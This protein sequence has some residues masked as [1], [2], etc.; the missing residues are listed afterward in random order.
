MAKEPLATPLDR[1]YGGFNALPRGI[2][3]GTDPSLIADGQLAFASNLSFRGDLVHT[4]SPLVS[5]PLD[6]QL[7]GMF[8]G[9]GFYEMPTQQGIVLTVA[10]RFYLIQVTPSDLGAVTDITPPAFSYPATIDFVHIFQAEKYAIFLGLQQKPVIYDGLTSRTAGIKE[11]PSGVLGLYA[12][13]RIWVALS[14]F[15]TFA[16]GDIVYG[17]S[18]TPAEG[19]VDAILKFTE[20][21]FLNEGGFFAVPSSAGTITAMIALATIDTS[22]GIGPILIGTNT[23]VISVNA[24]VDRTTWKNLQY[25]I[26]TISLL[27]YGPVGPRSTVSAFNDV[28]FRSLDGVRSFIVARRN[29]VSPG[30]VPLSHEVSPVLANDDDPLLFKGSAIVFD[31]RLFMTVAPRLVADSGTVHDGLAV[32]NFDSLSTMAGKQ[33]PIWE[34]VRS[35]LAILQVVRGHIRGVERAFALALN[36][37]NGVIELWEITRE[38]SGYY[39]TYRAVAGD[40]TSIVRTSI[41]TA[42]ETKR[43]DYDRLVK[44]VMG[45]L[46]LDDIVDEITL[47]IK[48]KPDEYPGWITWATIHLC[49]SVSQCTIATPE[50]FTCHIWKPNAR[51]YAARI[52]LPRPPETC[53]EIAGTPIDRAY[54][55]QFRLEGTGHFQTRKFRPHLKVESDA[56]E[57]TCPTSAVCTA[58]ENC[59]LPWFDYTIDRG[60]MAPV[61]DLSVASTP[62]N[63]IVEWE[64]ASA[65]DENEVWRSK[66]GG[67]FALLATVAG[68]VTSYADT[69]AMAAMDIWCYKVRG[70]GTDF[71]NVGCAVQDLIF[72]DTGAVSQPTWMLAYGDFGADNPPAVTSLSLPA[73]KRV[74]GNLFLDGMTALTSLSL[75]ALQ[76]V[77][78]T[79]LL[80]LSTMPALTFPALTTVGAAIDASICSNLVTLDAPVLAS[81][82]GNV[83]F[84]SNALVTVS[85]P[86]LVMLNGKTYAF[87]NNAMTAASVEGL[88]ARGAAQLPGLTTASILLDAGTN[89]G[90]A[91]LS[92]QGQ[93]DR[94]DLVAAGDTVPVN[95]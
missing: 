61:L 76:S 57:G 84:D 25:P 60:V 36:E 28:W 66:N 93:S 80:S 48:F 75:P 77:G 46:Y 51:T 38:N 4:R 87:D 6:M 16:A 13:G 73:L 24:P 64:Q 74:Y 5:I 68:T 52:R 15:R 35:G 54:S 21:D 2:D 12:W 42:L 32:I 11:I 50:Q 33:P 71:S 37:S 1:L 90:L 8:G 26:Q 81:V 67:A 45:E 27:D 9:A 70:T 55:F 88:L 83:E 43:F 7:T 19:G 62:G 17:P 89:A 40:H 44:L 23:S 86:V 31:N 49:A 20:N 47:V 59:E 82:G 22:L 39:D 78:V 41:Q 94:A 29:T 10:G 95:P 3:Y 79:F 56:F 53:N 91:S 58:V 34:G 65:P 69:D 14:D 30:N 18:G 72:L 63:T 85:L 92:A